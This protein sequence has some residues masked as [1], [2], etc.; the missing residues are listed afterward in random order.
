[1]CPGKEEAFVLDFVNK[2]EEIQEAFQLYYNTAPVLT[3][4]P[5]P[6]QLYDLRANIYGTHIVY[7]IEVSSPPFFSAPARRRIRPATL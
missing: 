2:P 6:R 4:E 5:D 7:E 1:M 3:S